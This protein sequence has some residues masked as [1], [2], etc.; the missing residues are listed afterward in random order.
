MSVRKVEVKPECRP[1]HY[2]TLQDL[3]HGVYN[4][5]QTVDLVRHQC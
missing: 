4:T 5:L 1:T 3:N 2:I